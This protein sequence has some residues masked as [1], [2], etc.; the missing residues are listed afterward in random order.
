MG[1]DPAAVGGIL[2]AGPGGGDSIGRI[3]PRGKTPTTPR[4]LLFY[5]TFL[6]HFCQM[7]RTPLR[8]GN[9]SVCRQWRASG[10]QLNHRRGPLP[11]AYGTVQEADYQVTI[12]SNATAGFSDIAAS[13][14]DSLE[15]A[16]SGIIS[17]GT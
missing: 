3:S 17:T 5:L 16:I 4:P 12:P 13:G 7:E 14:S 11:T 1:R 2:A 6:R 9:I 15:T 8:A 10:A